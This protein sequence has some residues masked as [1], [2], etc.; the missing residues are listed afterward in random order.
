VWVAGEGIGRLFSGLPSVLGDYPGA[1]M[2]YAAAAV[3]FPRRPPREQAGSAAEAGVMGQRSRTGWLG[4]WIGAAYS[5]ALPQNGEG[6][7]PFMLTINHSEAPGPLRALDGAELGW[8][9]VGTTDML[10]IAVAAACL[11]VGFTVFL[12]SCPGCSCPWSRWRD[13]W[14]CRTSA[15]SSPAQL[16]TW[17]PARS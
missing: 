10:G 6:G 15:A 4:L 2:L 7:L 8:L 12:G 13:G 14:A 5:T 16:S 3:L 9:T 1:A 11:A 17:A